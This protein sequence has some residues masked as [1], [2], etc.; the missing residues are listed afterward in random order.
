[1]YTSTMNRKERRRKGIK[2]TPATLNISVRDMAKY[3][4]KDIVRYNRCEH[5]LVVPLK[6]QAQ[7]MKELI[8]KYRSRKRKKK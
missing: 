7:Y 1:M 4:Q 6:I 2:E 8:D 5:G 3:C